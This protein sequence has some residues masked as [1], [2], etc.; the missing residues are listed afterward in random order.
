MNTPCLRHLLQVLASY[1]HLIDLAQRPGAVQPEADWSLHWEVQPR[2]F[3]QLAVLAA[4]AGRADEVLLA[5]DPDREGEA[6][7]W[8]LLQELQVCWGWGGIGRQLVSSCSRQ[9]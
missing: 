5:T 3:Q 9:T 6:I 1:G 2:G 8:H 7:S 4:A